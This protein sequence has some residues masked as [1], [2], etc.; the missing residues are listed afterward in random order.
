[1]AFLPEEEFAPLVEE[2]VSVRVL[3]DWCEPFEGYCLY[4]PSRRQPSPALSLVLDALRFTTAG[5]ANGR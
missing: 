1:M 4:Y 3:D 5:G 2:G